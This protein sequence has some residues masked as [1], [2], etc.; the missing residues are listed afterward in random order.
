MNPDIP[1]RNTSQVDPDVAFGQNEGLWTY[2]MAASLRTE[3]VR[4]SLSER[5]EDAIRTAIRHNGR[6]DIDVS[7]AT[8]ALLASLDEDTKR[9]RSQ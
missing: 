4:L 7:L 6:E 9:Q 2:R 1:E 5:A 3:I 8:E